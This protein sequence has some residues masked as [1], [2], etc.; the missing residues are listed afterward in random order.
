M[1]YLRKLLFPFSIVYG[2]VIR[3][4]NFFYHVGILKS[5]TFDVPVICV[6]NLSTGGTGKT[7]LVEFLITHL[8]S[9]KNVAVLSRGYGRTSIGFI[10]VFVNHSAQFAGDEPLQIKQKFEKANVFVC[11]DR[12]EGINT[13]LKKHPLTD[14]VILDDAFQHRRVKAGLNIVITAYGNLFNNDM[15]LPAGNLRE[16]ASAIKRAQVV[17]VSKCPDDLT[18]IKKSQIRTE[19]EL[20]HQQPL[21]FSYLRY[22][23]L[24]HLFSGEKISLSS[25]KQT[26][27]LLLTGIASSKLL[28]KFLKTRSSSVQEI[29][30]AD[31]HHFTN[32]NLQSVTQ[33]F[34]TIASPEK[35]IV[36]TEKDAVKLR[37]EKINNPI[38]KFPVYILPVKAEF[39][40]IEEH[41]FK[42]IIDNYVG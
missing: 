41:K 14:V 20:N 2:V 38:K 39:E 27:I 24:C 26:N 18:T 22:N 4:R 40:N 29:K 25:L 1:W 17:I 31:H 37:D 15:M 12:V 33:K 7:P 19:L 30:F 36:C 21:F 42:S 8:I 16:P 11:E 34:D 13:I 10:E 3:T 28:I 35:I 32:E 23:D 5:V 6:G 9:N